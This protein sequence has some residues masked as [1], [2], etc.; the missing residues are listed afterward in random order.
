MKDIE[1][2][3]ILQALA[4]IAIPTMV[5]GLKMRHCAKVPVLYSVCILICL[6]TSH[7][8]NRLQIKHLFFNDT[9]FMN[10]VARII[11]HSVEQRYTLLVRI[12]ITVFWF[13]NVTFCRNRMSSEAEFTEVWQNFLQQWSQIR[14]NVQICLHRRLSTDRRVVCNL[15]GFE[16][17]W[18]RRLG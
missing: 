9:F 17:R 12:Q 6:I 13:K 18:S 11:F 3:V 1:C 16:Q 5:N 4:K 2:W 7:S 15:S 10:L 14:F 8:T